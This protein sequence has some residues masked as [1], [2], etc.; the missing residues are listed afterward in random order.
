LRLW[1]VRE[2]TVD[3]DDHENSSVSIMGIPHAW[4]GL[5][6][7]PEGGAERLGSG[8]RRRFGHRSFAWTIRN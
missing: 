5:A 1:A 6:A 4:A 3:V 2:R 8:F 7:P